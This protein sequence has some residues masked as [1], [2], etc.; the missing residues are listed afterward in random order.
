MSVSWTKEQQK[1]IDT[2]GCNILV[3]AAAGSGKTAVLVERIIG[4]L[5]KDN[6]P[7]NVDELL[8]VTYTE[9]AAAEMKERLRDALEKALEEQPDNA[10]ILKQATLVHN[11]KITT[12]HSFCLSVIREHFHEIDLDP[13]FRIAEE[14]ELKLLKQ[15]VLEAVLESAYE[16]ADEAF[17]DFTESYATGRDDKKLEELILKVYEFSRSFPSPR[18]WMDDCARQYEAKNLA[19]LEEKAFIKAIVKNTRNYMESMKTVLTHARELCRKPSGPVNYGENM[20]LALEN[21]ER[22]CKEQTFC[23]MYQKICGLNWGRLKAN[24]GLE[25]EKELEETVKGLKQQV[26]DTVDDLVKQYFYEEPE[27]MRKDLFHTG[28]MAAV[29]FDL[30][31]CFSTR[32]QEE[33]AAKNLIDFGDMEHMAM[34]ILTVYR[35]GAFRPTKTAK[36]YQKQFKEIMIDEYQDSNFIQETILSSVSGVENGNYNIFMVGDVKQSIYRFRLSRPELFIEKFETYSQTEGEKVRIDLHKNFRSR[37]EVLQ[38]VNYFFEKIMDK[39]LGDVAYDEKAALYPGAD[40]EEDETN[41]GMHKV[42]MHLIDAN[43]EEE[44]LDA[45]R[46]KEWEARFIAARIK[47]L[48][49]TY[50]VQDKATKKPRPVRFADMVILVR[51]PKSY[52]DTFGKVFAEEGIPVY[53]GSKEGYF[54]AQEIRVLLDYLRILDNRRQDIPLAGVMLSVIGGFANEDLAKIRAEFPSSKFCEA[55]ICYPEQG[56]EERLREKTAKFWEQVERFRSRIPYTAIHELLF[57][58]MD[59][60]GYEDYMEAFPDGV[61]RSANIRMLVEKARA[62]ECTSYKGVFHFVRYIEKLHKYEVDYGEANVTDEAA[63]VVRIMSIHKSKGLEF[64]VVFVAGMNGKFNTQDYKNSVCVHPEFGV[65]M[66]CVDLTKRT[67]APTILKRMMQRELRLE[68]AGEELRLL[69]VAMTRAK[70]KLILVGS[71]PEAEKKIASY[72]MWCGQGDKLPFYLR[73]GADSYYSFLI[74]A[75]EG[76][77]TLLEIDVKVAYPLEFYEEK[78]LEEKVLGWTKENYERLPVERP[79]DQDMEQIIK[80]QFAFR[81][82]FEEEQKRKQKFTVSELKR[83]QME[84]EYSENMYRENEEE[85]YVPSFVREEETGGAIRGT[86]FHKMLEL[87]DFTKQASRETIQNQMKMWGEQGFMK[88]EL[89]QLVDSEKM[90]TFL[91]TDLARRM[92]NAQKNGKLYREQPFVIGVDP[93]EIYEGEKGGE[94]VLVQG[95]I[96]VWF[97]EPDGVV[98]LDYKTD[99]V[100]TKEEL[101]QRYERQLYYYSQAIERMAG[102][103]VKEHL[104][105]SFALGQLIEVEYE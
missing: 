82:T 25:V 2:R 49:R 33:K 86:A 45:A 67:K 26:K 31:E 41:E 87:W 47:K 39:D 64:P 73:A 32:F 52:G 84:D 13:G 59:E 96:D 102:K 12:I 104:I 3:S 74:P 14:G 34:Q 1:V 48:L 15:D 79:F 95:I 23:G 77:N 57:Q 29:L 38:G 24:R 71:V 89:L 56:A 55:V 60:T 4:R 22:L 98:L 101:I 99:R 70:E 18:Q 28:R 35:D 5:I 66:D 78:R 9:A 10:H 11:A 90:E 51:S 91:N 58:I 97:E 63:D 94:L 30:V 92:G 40:F 75:L 93:E 6:P 54:E 21:V 37:K 46:E 81:Y 19:D 105:Y 76:K 17:L 42:E 80:G 44:K 83:A 16:E 72:G 88:E 27:E 103:P 53:T 68:N 69:Y 36:E 61:K 20:E 100:S 43:E 50:T 85:S 7:L 62:F 8:V 65:G